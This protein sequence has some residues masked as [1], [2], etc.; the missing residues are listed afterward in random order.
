MSTEGLELVFIL[1]A[2][3]A[4]PVKLKEQLLNERWPQVSR[5]PHAFPEVQ[6]KPG[7]LAILNASFVRNHAALFSIFRQWVHPR[8]VKDRAL[9]WALTCFLSLCLCGMVWTKRLWRQR[10]PRHHP[11]SL[12]HLACYPRSACCCFTEMLL[13]VQVASVLP[14]VFCFLRILWT[15]RITFSCFL[16]FLPSLLPFLW[17]MWY[18]P[19][20]F[21]TVGGLQE[22]LASFI[23]FMGL[24]VVFLMA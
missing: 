16:K 10:L 22:V 14:W 3:R 11:P 20:P 7:E 12:H 24:L 17:S 18:Y 8:W 2:P 6:A 1:R 13:M 21:C 9:K 15:V 19:L 23:A 5:E 4:A